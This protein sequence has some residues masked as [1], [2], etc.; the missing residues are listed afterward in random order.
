[1]VRDKLVPETLSFMMV[2]PVVGESLICNQTGRIILRFLSTMET[3]V[4]FTSD[5]DPEVVR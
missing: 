4:R 3:V 2:A 5:Q 1:M